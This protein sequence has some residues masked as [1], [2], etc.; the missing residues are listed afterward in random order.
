[1]GL[2][3]DRV[4]YLKIYLYQD[5]DESNVHLEEL[6]KFIEKNFG[7]S[8]IFLRG[9]FIDFH[10]KDVK[11]ENLAKQLAAIRV[12]DIY[13]PHT[14]YTPFY[15]EIDFE[16]R[17]LTGK[18]KKIKGILYDDLKLLLLFWDLL[19]TDERTSN[20]IHIVIT[21]R[22]FGTFSEGDGRYHIRSILCS[23]LSLIS[24]AG[25]IEGPAKP[26]LFY[27]LKHQSSAMGTNLPIE[28]FKQQFKGQFIDYDDPNLTEVLKGYVSQALFFNLTG[29]PFCSDKT[30]RLFN[31]HW[32]AEL[33]DAQLGHRKFCES[34]QKSLE[35]FVIKANHLKI[36]KKY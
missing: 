33:I 34:H 1:M 18:I 8:E 2:N 14:E 3:P 16:R 29:E 4:L 32:Q 24:T 22:L 17:F 7:F 26:R 9:K 10:N 30:C 12:K 25:I 27:K 15:G 20:K 35:N 31:A 23:R 36:D 5:C 11:I 13:Q 6:Q 21:N 19:P 28:V